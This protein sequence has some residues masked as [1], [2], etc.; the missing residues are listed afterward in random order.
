MSGAFTTKFTA[1]RAYNI[2]S[3]VANGSTHPGGDVIASHCG[4]NLYDYVVGST[5]GHA[6]TSSAINT[7]LQ[8]Y[9][10]GPML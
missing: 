5:G 6:H 3:Y 9:Y 10:I 7:I 1:N 8:S 2:T 4:G